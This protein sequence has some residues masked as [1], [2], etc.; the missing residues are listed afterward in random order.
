MYFYESGWIILRFRVYTK[1]IKREIL[2]RRKTDLFSK[3]IDDFKQDLVKELVF[4]IT[5][6]SVAGPR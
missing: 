3:M 5:G 4:S 6:Q 2:F 1:S